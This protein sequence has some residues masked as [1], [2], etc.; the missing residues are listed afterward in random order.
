MLP[1]LLA[2]L[3]RRHFRIVHVVPE[4][5]GPAAPS[6]LLLAKR[7]APKLGW[8][9]VVPVVQAPSIARL[10][11]PRLPQVPQL[12]ASAPQ[13]LQTLARTT[14]IRALRLA[15]GAPPDTEAAISPLRVTAAA[16][17]HAVRDIP[18]PP[19]KGHMMRRAM[20]GRSVAPLAKAEPVAALAFSRADVMP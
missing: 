15:G 20:H 19:H 7:R 3:K 8:P 1:A 17:P 2:E 12:A 4:V 5:V 14:A 16:A 11:L 6:P 13:P 10:T 18:M 9:R